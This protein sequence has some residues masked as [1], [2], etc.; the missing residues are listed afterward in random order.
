MISPDFPSARRT[1]WIGADFR[2]RIPFRR[3]D[4]GLRNRFAFRITGPPDGDF[5]HPKTASRPPRTDL[6]EVLSGDQVEDGIEPVD[7]DREATG[8]NG[9]RRQD[10]V[11]QV[12][13]ERETD[14][15]R[16]AAAVVPSLQAR[17][18][19]LTLTR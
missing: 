10:G 18:R 3:G 13:V 14:D 2:Q 9:P 8:G 17:Q 12:I 5:R 11:F 6:D 1:E 19:R 16:P 4:Q 7:A 15:E